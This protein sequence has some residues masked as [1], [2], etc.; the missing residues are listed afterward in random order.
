MEPPHF[1][2]TLNFLGTEVRI[3]PDPA[4]PVVIHAL[5]T[6]AAGHIQIHHLGL[7]LL[8]LGWTGP[9]PWERPEEVALEA[10]TR[11]RDGLYAELQNSESLRA[12]P[13]TRKQVE[14]E[15]RASIQHFREAEAALEAVRILDLPTSPG[16][17]ARLAARVQ[18]SLVGS[19]APVQ[20]VTQ[21][22]ADAIN[23]AAADSSAGWEKWAQME[24]T[25]F[26]AAPAGISSSGASELPTATPATPS[27]GSI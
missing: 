20:M 13:Q 16:D 21:W 22:A 12:D 14:A 18:A 4:L 17:R 27:D 24:A 25:G 2:Y 5:R 19:G 7:L 8:A 1:P 3:D 6:N 9:K 15:Y 23:R 26:S 11:K 10:A